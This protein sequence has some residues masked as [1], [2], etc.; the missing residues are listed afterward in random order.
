MGP[1]GV[2]EQQVFFTAEQR[3]VSGAA[4]YDRQ[5]LQPVA[6]VERHLELGLQWQVRTVVTRLSPPGRAVALRVPLLPGENVLSEGAMVR[7]GMMEVRLGAQDPAF[8]WESGLTPG[9]GIDLA[10]RTGD[11][12]VERWHVVASPVWNLT[13]SGLGPV[14]E[15]ERA[16]LVQVWHPWPGES[17]R[18]ELLRPEALAG[19]TMTV[20]RATH[21]V[22]VGRR[23]RVA[24][25]DLSVRSSLGE[26]FVMELPEGAEVT[27]LQHDGQAVPVRRDGRKL[28]VPV[29]PGEQALAVG[30]KL[31]G[32]IGARAEPG[33]VRLPVEA[34][35]VGTVLEVPESRWVLWASG[36]RRGPAVRF[37]VILVC[38]LLA[39]VLLARPRHSPLRLVE[40]LL[41][42]VGLTQVPFPAAAVVVVWLWVLAWRGLAP[43]GRWTPVRYNLMQVGLVLLTVAALGILVTAVGEGL[44]GSPEMFITGNGSTRTRLAWFQDRTAGPLPEPWYVAV[45]IRWYRLLMLLWALW[46]AMSLIRW[47]GVGWRNFSIGGVIRRGVK[48]PPAPPAPPPIPTPAP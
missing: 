11:G 39:A 13:F 17:A 14:F 45:S 12:W 16:D 38:A 10:T 9:T 8:T 20:A 18:L 22:Q 26:D 3:V 7:D 4:S 34:A 32:E 48:T 24:S 35:N 1:D 47:L 21:A 5:E 29:R 40:W 30:W 23:Q 31:S 19:A 36:P 2:P 37:W 15:G 28:I 6:R 27:S 41:L 44:L 25:L 43:C 33:E 42:G 46:L